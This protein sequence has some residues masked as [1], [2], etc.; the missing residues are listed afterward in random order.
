LR[1]GGIEIGELDCVVFC[2]KPLVKFERMLQTYLGF[3]PR[4]L[5]SFTAAMPVWI[6]EKL[7]LQSLLKRELAATDE[8]NGASL[9]PIG[10]Q[11]IR[12]RID[13]ALN[14][15]VLTARP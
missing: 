5:S 12:Q 13:P 11:T 1:A 10:H 8:C 9:P 6:K 15:K 4:G 14:E 7:F 3:A 2:D